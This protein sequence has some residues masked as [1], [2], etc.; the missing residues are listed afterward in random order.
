MI[1]A[2]FAIC[3]AIALDWAF[4]VSQASK[5]KFPSLSMPWNAMPLPVFSFIRSCHFFLNWLDV[6][7]N[8]TSHICVC[9]LS[10]KSIIRGPF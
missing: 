7:S 8:A 3:L 6:G 4:V 9:L 10:H 1:A 2:C 5:K